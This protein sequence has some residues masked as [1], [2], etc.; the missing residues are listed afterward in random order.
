MKDRI[1][2][3]LGRGLEYYGIAYFLN[4]QYDCEL[5]SIIQTEYNTKEFYKNQKLIPFKK[6][7]FFHDYVITQNKVPDKKYL[8]SIEKKYG[9]NIW[10]IA[11]A[12]RF[13]WRR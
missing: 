4:H 9:I 5:F 12:E 13:F 10:L 2:F 11:Y 6:I 8:S 3:W 7:W 1:L